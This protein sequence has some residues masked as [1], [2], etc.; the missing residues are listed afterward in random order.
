VLGLIAAVVVL[1]RFPNPELGTTPDD[2]DEITALS[3]HSGISRKRPVRRL[4]D[5][6]STF[7]G[8]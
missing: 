2:P 1:I 5:A 7:N 4:R 8:N 3:I 6:S